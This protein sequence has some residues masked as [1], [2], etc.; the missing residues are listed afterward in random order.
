MNDVFEK[1]KQRYPVGT[2]MQHN[3]MPEKQFRIVSYHGHEVTVASKQIKATTHTL[4]SHRFIWFFE[5]YLKVEEEIH[6]TR[7][8]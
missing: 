1:L 4:K 3:L 5:N 6:N 7:L 2:L 8:L